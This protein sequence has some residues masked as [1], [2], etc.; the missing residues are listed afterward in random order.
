MQAGMQRPRFF[1]ED[2]FESR[3]LFLSA[4]ADIGAQI[5]SFILPDHTG[6]AGEEL[7][8]DIAW[9]GDESAH[10]VFV[11][12]C[13]T[14][15]QE[16]FSGSAVQHAWLRSDEAR[17][18]PEGVAVCLVHANNP[19]GA[20]YNSRG[21]ENFVDLNRNY[22]AP[23][24]DIRPNRLYSELFELLFTNE[25]NEQVL[26]EV[27]GQFYAFAEANDTRE[28]MTAMGGGQNTHPSGTLYCGD[29]NEFSIQ[30]LRRLI[31]EKL[32]ER[33]NV[34][35]IDWHTGLGDFG[36]VTVLVKEP[37][38]SDEHRW[39]CA[40]W[41]G[42]SAFEALDPPEERADSI[43]LVHQG[44]TD[45]LRAQGVRAVSSVI[46]FGT[47]DNEA[48]LAALLIDRWLRFEC[49]DQKSPEAIRLRTM[50]MER[51]NPTTPAWRSAVVEKGLALYTKT[52]S[53]LANWGEP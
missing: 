41:G 50:M 1:G 22:F 5:D 14:H 20:A 26:H 25:M 11:S 32:C 13:G 18:L 19:Y 47:V 3:S 12:I 29:G 37:Y 49:K 38:A 35:I 31:H 44:M 52:I 21:N 48:V 27:M 43:G 15:G 4:T 39:S 40:W 46:E 6:P 36:D 7:A 23:G 53:G 8:T 2:Y 24:L 28:A 42:P 16:F 17:A 30:T 45:Q 10:S 9:I 51:L 33:R 34:A